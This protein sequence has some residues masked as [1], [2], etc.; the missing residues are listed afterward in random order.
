MTAPH[1]KQGWIYKFIPGTSRLA[2]YVRRRHG[3][4]RAGEPALEV[5]YYSNKIGLTGP[6]LTRPDPAGRVRRC[7]KPVESGRGGFK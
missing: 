5:Q 6:A 4:V 3:R 7:S 2:L 1:T